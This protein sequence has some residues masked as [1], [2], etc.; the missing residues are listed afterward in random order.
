MFCGGTLALLAKQG[1]A[2]NYLCATRGEGGELGEPPVCARDELGHARQGEMAC[3]V[4]ALGG[5]QLVFLD[6]TALILR[7]MSWHR[8]FIRESYLGHCCHGKA[9]SR[10]GRGLLT[11]PGPRPEHPRLGILSRLLGFP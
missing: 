3:A 10:L 7:R 8:F 6:Y 2:V 11:H 5:R 4:K 9:V 1:A